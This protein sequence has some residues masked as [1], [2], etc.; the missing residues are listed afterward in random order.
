MELLGLEQGDAH[1]E[2]KKGS[3]R[4][5]GGRWEKGEGRGK[6]EEVYGEGREKDLDSK[7]GWGMSRQ[8]ENGAEGGEEWEGKRG[9]K[10]MELGKGKAREK[11]RGGKG[12][13]EKEQGQGAGTEHGTG[14]RGRKELGKSMDR[15]G[16]AMEKGQS[17]LWEVNSLGSQLAGKSLSNQLAGN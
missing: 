13:E 1:G 15:K 12:G 16:R 17:R 4:K 7:P 9:R 11:K 5:D 14:E 6:K 3:R 2:S 10:G 8:K